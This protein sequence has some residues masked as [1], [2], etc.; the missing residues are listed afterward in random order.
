MQSADNFVD[1]I[2]DLI[3]QELSKTD[4]TILCE[5]AAKGSKENCYDV[6]I[7]PDY[8]TIIHNIPN[9]TRFEPKNG[10]YVYV[11]KINND[12]N[13]SFICCVKNPG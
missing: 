13:N 5:V 9:Q 7:V 12:F 10:D 2:K 6:Y 1:L 8:H 3:K 4:Q 11:Y